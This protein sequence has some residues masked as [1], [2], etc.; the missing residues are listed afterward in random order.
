MAS[1]YVRMGRT[2][3][4][5]FLIFCICST[6]SITLRSFSLSSAAAITYSHASV[7]HS[8]HLLGG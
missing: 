1:N 7:E 2:S 4:V 5:N 6:A 8:R 3:V